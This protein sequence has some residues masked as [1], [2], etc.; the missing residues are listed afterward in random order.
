MALAVLDAAIANVALP[1]IG[2]SLAVTPAMAIRVVTAYQLGVVI[3]LLPAAA[4]GESIG[5]RRV[6]TAGVVLF[7]G[8]SLLCTFAPSLTWLVAARFLQGIGGAAIMA[9]GIALLRFIVPPH[10]LGTAI[11]W[12]ALVVALSSAAG[13]MIG[14]AII[15]VG[16]WPWLFVINLPTG[17]LVLLAT[18]TVPAL[19]GTGRSLNL[20]SVVLN[21][22]T[23]A[24]LMIGAEYA[25]S[26]PIVTATMFAGAL[27]TGA[28]L[29]GREGH[30]E[31]PL[32]PVDLLR[33]S[34]FRV[35]VIASILCFAGQTAALVALPFH[36]QHAF[37]LSP[38]MTALYLLPW[39]LTVTLAGPLA[40]RLANHASTAW[41]CFIGG[42]LLASG[43]G[44]TAMVPGYYQPAAIG[45][46]MMI[47]GLGFGL[48]NVPNNRNMFMSAPIE[49]SGAAGGMQGVAR[50]TGQIAGALQMTFLFA[51]A[52]LAVAPRIGLAIGALMT[53][54]SGATSILRLQPVE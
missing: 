2:R 21:T 24:L 29:F 34:S 11:G 1:T 35:S 26:R 7:T 22:A 15:T 53:L 49:R 8:A 31:A 38:L 45:L 9:L 32:L 16:S 40:G 23:F 46:C 19:E 5:L 36:L 13:P 20:G 37:G 14:A 42:L 48:F 17:A 30:S 50:L 44:A 25:A 41:L 10:Q 51:F 3:M 18:R 47:C 27:S 12:N 43:L 39:P 28:M 6:F 52:S 4:L 33:M 54:A